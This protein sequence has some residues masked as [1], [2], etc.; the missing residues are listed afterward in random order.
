MTD[1]RVVTTSSS[2]RL[3]HRGP[4]SPGPE[5][6]SR[7]GSSASGGSLTPPS[8][9]GSSDAGR[10]AAAARRSAKFA[11][12]EGLSSRDVQRQYM[13][14]RSREERLE[15]RRVRR[16]RR[17]SAAA[18]AT[19][20]DA[21]PLRVRRFLLAVCCYAPLFSLWSTR[22][23]SIVDEL[24]DNLCHLPYA[25]AAACVGVAVAREVFR[26]DSL[27]LLYPVLSFWAGIVGGSY[28]PD[29]MREQQALRLGVM[30]LHGIL[31][32]RL[33]AS[34]RAAVSQE[35]GSVFTGLLFNY[36]LGELCCMCYRNLAS[37][38]TTASSAYLML[39]LLLPLAGAFPSIILTLW[40]KLFGVEKTCSLKKPSGL[41]QRC[42]SAAAWVVSAATPIFIALVAAAGTLYVV[43]P[44]VW[45]RMVFVA[46]WGVLFEVGSSLSCC[47]ERSVSL[48]WSDSVVP[49][50]PAAVAAA[51]AAAVQPA[52]VPNVQRGVQGA[53]A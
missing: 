16:S 50:R 46:P 52:T 27:S 20:H 28:S 4:P 22:L 43:L 24:G 39:L 26:L 36:T 29:A 53:R 33:R 5:R 19:R 9:P 30:C 49:A 51:A 7:C 15:E 1:L 2:R 37:E 23:P 38:V 18:A 32:G 21:A 42:V 44:I 14:M 47:S 48:F 31:A 25:L 35:P 12:F 34:E 40:V 10:G 6:D 11:G 13:Q 8:S 3:T 45:E 17:A 41:V